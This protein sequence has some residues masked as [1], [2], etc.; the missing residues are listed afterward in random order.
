MSDG[1]L[2]KNIVLVGFMG[3]GK[4][5]VSK[6]LAEVWQKEVISI[7]VL[8]EQSEGLPIPAIFTEKGQRYFRSLEKK[9]VSEVSRKK[10][11]IIDCGGGVVLDPENIRRLR[12]HGLIIC[13]YASPE[14]IFNRLKRKK[15]RPLL[16]VKEPKKRINQLLEV[17][18]EHYQQADHKVNT[19]NKT[20][21]EVCR[22]IMAL[23]SGK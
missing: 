18:K 14:V 2:S 15:N 16:D 9:I 20:V 19:D 13:L 1:K 6:K 7:D 12:K 10:D 11:V 4:S 5:K 23:V 17:R 22:E 21:T 8:I 3:T